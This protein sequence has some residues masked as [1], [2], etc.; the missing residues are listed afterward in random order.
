MAHHSKSFVST[1]VLRC[2]LSSCLFHILTVSLSHPILCFNMFIST[3]IF[4]SLSLSLSIFS[5]IYLNMFTSFSFSLFPIMFT[6]NYQ[7]IPIC[8]F[9]SFFLSQTQH[10]NIVSF[11]EIIYSVHPHLYYNELIFVCILLYDTRNATIERFLF[12]ITVLKQFSTHFAL[13]LIIIISQGK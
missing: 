9:L 12:S 11:S 8:S 3:F 13:V 1:I 2:S 7:S 6:S 4:L 10:N 5:S